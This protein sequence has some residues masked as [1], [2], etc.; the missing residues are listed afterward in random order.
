MN[1]MYARRRTQG[2][3]RL[4]IKSNMRNEI[5]GALFIGKNR[6]YF[7][8]QLIEVEEMSCI[9]NLESQWVKKKHYQMLSYDEPHRLAWLQTL[10]SLPR[11]M[12]CVPSV[13]RERSQKTIM[14]IKYKERKIHTKTTS[15]CSFNSFNCIC[16]ILPLDIISFSRPR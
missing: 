8:N 1:A 15:L 11:A 16:N 10:C 13:Q 4:L 6:L 14:E 2:S 7:F 12:C 9:P 3:W 5:W